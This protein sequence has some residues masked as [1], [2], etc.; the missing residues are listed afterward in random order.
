MSKFIPNDYQLKVW[1]VECQ[2]SG[3]QLNSVFILL[4]CLS[5]SIY[6]LL[7]QVTAELH[8]SSCTCFW[9]TDWLKGEKKKEQSP[10]SFLLSGSGEI[11]IHMIV[12]HASYTAAALL[13][14]H[15]LSPAVLS[16]CLFSV[17]HLKYCLA[18]CSPSPVFPLN[19]IILKTNASCR[20]KH[21]SCWEHHP[22]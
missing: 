11:L 16:K 8:S 17:S 21:H 1:L 20:K 19:S 4:A 14:Q 9:I 13:T 12:Y 5:F 6:Y 3:V 7:L 22:L 2:N 15:H 10:T 18:F